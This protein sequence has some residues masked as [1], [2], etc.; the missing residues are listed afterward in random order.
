MLTMLSFQVKMQMIYN[1]RNNL[2]TIPSLSYLQTYF[3]LITFLA[4]AKVS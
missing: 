2:S 1:D 3:A 4:L